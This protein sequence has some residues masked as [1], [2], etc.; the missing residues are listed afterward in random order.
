MVA[1]TGLVPAFMLTC[2]PKRVAVYPDHTEKIA[3]KTIH[4]HFVEII[5]LPR[6]WLFFA[7]MFLAGGGEFCLT[8]WSAS[9]VQLNF[10]A[11]AWAGG[12]A[13]AFFAV[14]M[15]L[16]RTGWGYLIKQHQL[17]KLIGFSALAGVVICITFPILT[18][19]WLFF[20]LLLLA[21][22]ATAP[23]WP[24]IQ[25][26]CTDR[27]DKLDTTMLF[28]LLSCAGIPGCGFFTLLM[29]YIGNQT[30]SLAD[31]FYL[32]PICFGLIAIL[33][34]CDSL[35]GRKSNVKTMP[36]QK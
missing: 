11:P 7:A 10:N 24:S 30:G 14:G 16:G 35:I 6:F 18:N 22:I 36:V 17:N 1:V 29:G 31:A 32:I 28:I 2:P 20:A 33:M 34:L 8:F 21:G 15:V 4:N 13:T 27:L 19:L 3:W 26:H 5:S 9:Y 12:V 23:L 25:S